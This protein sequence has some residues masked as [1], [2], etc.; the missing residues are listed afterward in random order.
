MRPHPWGNVYSIRLGKHQF[1]GQCYVSCQY[2]RATSITNC[3]YFG[4]VVAESAGQFDSW[5]KNRTVESTKK[6]YRIRTK[7][8]HD[9][10]SSY[11]HK[12]AETDPNEQD[13]AI[14]DYVS[15]NKIRLE[16]RQSVSNIQNVVHSIFCRSHSR[17]VYSTV[18]FY[19][20]IIIIC[21]LNDGTVAWHRAEER[22]KN[23]TVLMVFTLRLRGACV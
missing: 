1:V 2:M 7:Q 15:N 23:E 18:W 10:T 5:K 12:C 21:P 17:L 19:F 13:T 14:V 20:S 3:V 6:T 8:A 4:I 16:W 11:A 9:Y 22:K